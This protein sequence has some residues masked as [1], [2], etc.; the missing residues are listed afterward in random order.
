MVRSTLLPLWA[1]GGLH[2]HLAEYPKIEPKIAYLCP[3]SSLMVTPIIKIQQVKIRRGIKLHFDPY[4][5]FWDGDF[6]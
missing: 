4:G 6:P 1:F 3:V 5:V 2:G